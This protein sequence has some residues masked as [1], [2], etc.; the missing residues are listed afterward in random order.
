M[1]TAQSARERTYTDMLVDAINLLG[2]DVGNISMQSLKTAYRTAAYNYHPDMNDGEDSSKLIFEEVNASNQLLLDEINNGGSALRSLLDEWEDIMRKRKIAQEKA[3][4]PRFDIANAGDYIGLEP[5]TK[6]YAHQVVNFNRFKDK[7]FFAL[8]WDMGTGKSK[9]AIDLAAYKYLNGEIDA[10]IVI[11]PNNVHLQWFRQ[12]F[13]EHCPIGYEPFVWEQIKWGN[14]RY[15]TAYDKFMDSSLDV[16]KVFFMNVETFQGEQGQQ[17]A[18]FFTRS[19]RTMVVL[20][21]ATTD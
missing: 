15:R 21:E 9:M 10:V 2:L 5:K 12:Q 6:P 20:D 7:V 13:P 19:N 18:K 4:K 3:Q 14:S 8:F 1:S 16:L 11:A 17:V